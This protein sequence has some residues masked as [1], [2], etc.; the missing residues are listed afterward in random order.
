MYT[1]TCDIV[2]TREEVIDGVTKE[3]EVVAYTGLK[4]RI[5]FYRSSLALLTKGDYYLKKQLVTLF[6]QDEIKVKEGSKIIVTQNGET[7]VYKNSGKAKLYLTHQ[8]IILE[9]VENLV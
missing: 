4:C 3:E 1:G 6:L 2:E 5:S 9:L 8:E 7:S